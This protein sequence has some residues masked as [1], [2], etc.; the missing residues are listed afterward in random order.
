[1]KKKPEEL[2]IAQHALQ[3]LEPIPKENWQTFEYTNNEGACCL[4]GHYNRLTS[5]NP[6]DY[7]DENCWD[8]KGDKELRSATKKF[9]INTYQI[10][11][12]DGADV[13]NQ[14]NINGYIE[15]NP[16]DRCIHLLQDMVKAGY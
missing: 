16:K 4:L 11:F 3:L 13:N 10:N 1:M 7:S 8:G 2:T 6:N 14:N 5:G 12:V 15:D 9:L